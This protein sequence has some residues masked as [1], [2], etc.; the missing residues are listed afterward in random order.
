MSNENVVKKAQG[1]DW[2]DDEETQGQPTP[3][4]PVEKVIAQDQEEAPKQKKVFTLADVKRY[5][6]VSVNLPFM[7][8]DYEPWSFKLRLKLSEDADE[9][10]Q[11]YLALSA[12]EQTR[13]EQ[14]QALD[15]ICDLLTEL[16]KGF[17]DLIP[18]SET[19]RG[20]SQPGVVFKEWVNNITD[21]DGKQTVL[22]I[23]ASA[24]RHYWGTILP[25]EFR[26]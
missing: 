16:P 22:N 3:K 8:Q 14:D 17:G 23:V 1:A 11:E 26:G 21:P 12:A 19:K 10:R 7:Y 2:E 20:M 5:V 4:S 25:R 13:K 9:R 24:D 18:L 15:E 6:P